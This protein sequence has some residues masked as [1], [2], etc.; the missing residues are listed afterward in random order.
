MEQVE[1][2]IA[3]ANRR[4]PVVDSGA[5]NMANMAI[6]AGMAIDADRMGRGSTD[7]GVGLSESDQLGGMG[8][9]TAN[10]DVDRP[11][12]P[13]HVSPQ[14]LLHG[15]QSTQVAADRAT[16]DPRSHS[17]AARPLMAGTSAEQWV[18]RTGWAVALAATFLITFAR[19]TR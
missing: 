2:T 17:A 11:V 8:E 9:T 19:N 12:S 7:A 18:R 13:T 16:P 3:S 5:V 4:A 14:V 15:V 10:S 6:E 1:R